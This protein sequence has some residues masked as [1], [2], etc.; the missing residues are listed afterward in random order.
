MNNLLHNYPVRS[1][2]AESYRTLRT[3]VSFSFMEQSF[4]TLL[5]TSAG[6]QE[7]K[8]TTAA[9]LAYTMA[10]AGNSVLLIDADL[11]KPTL[12]LLKPMQS[13]T[14]LSGLLAD[15]LSTDVRSGSLSEFGLGDL[16]RLI[17]FQKK[18][19]ILHLSQ[20]EDRVDLH[21]FHGKL[22]DAEWLTRPRERS[23]GTVLVNNKVITQDQLEQV[24]VSQ[25]DTGQKLG[26]MLLNMGLVKKEELTGFIVLHIIEAFR[27]GFQFKTGE[28]VFENL[29]E[30]DF[31]S[32]A[33][34]PEDLPKL[35]RQAMVGEEK[36]NFLEKKTASAI[37][38]MDTENFSV[39]PAGLPPPNPAEL[40]DSER[41]PFLIYLL[42]RQ[43]DILIIDTPPILPA[44]DAMILAPHTDGIL[45]VIQSG[46]LKRELIK[47]AV[48]QIKK[49]QANLI[50]VVLNQVD[51][52]K[53]GYYSGEY[54]YATYYG[55]GD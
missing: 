43:F 13:S 19:G 24:L 6:E 46:Y 40:L 55:E 5:V 4:R 49:T 2:F 8:T 52:K 41:M 18:T 34:T 11:R 7:G 42:K 23:L 45:L 32:D 53:A 48:N 51:V 1:H 17:S 47:K 21:F 29:S 20:G 54:Y 26:F 10:Q 44:S 22:F 25:K 27:S 35:Y 37:V 15:V 12:N 33:F 50:G 30:S 9:N 3:N 39:L 36:L 28:F 14:G 31:A 38:G 16:Y